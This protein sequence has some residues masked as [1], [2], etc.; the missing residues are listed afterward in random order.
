MIEI[1]QN[2]NCDRRHTEPRDG[3]WHDRLLVGSGVRED[4]TLKGYGS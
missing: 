2:I 4:A 3:Q 1:C